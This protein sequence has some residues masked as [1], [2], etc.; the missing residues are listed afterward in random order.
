MGGVGGAVREASWS[1]SCNRAA[2]PGGA[3]REVSANGWPQS[4]LSC[5]CQG[6]TYLPFS[7]TPFQPYPSSVPV[8]QRL[9]GTAEHLL[10]ELPHQCKSK[11]SSCPERLSEQPSSQ[12]NGLQTLFSH[13][14]RKATLIKQALHPFLPG[15][16]GLQ[17]VTGGEGRRR[18]R[19]LSYLLPPLPCGWAAGHEISSRRW[20]RG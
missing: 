5:C 16:S 8:A 2:L 10:S 18:W 17:A 12:S 14:V 4:P 19:Q 11:R 20:G 15:C 13:T 9:R 7:P 3:S 1:C 6:S